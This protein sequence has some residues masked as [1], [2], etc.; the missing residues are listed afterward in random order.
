MNETIE[1]PTI[2]KP[3]L[4]GLTRLLAKTLERQGKFDQRREVS[5]EVRF[6]LW[7][8]QSD[9]GLKH[10]E[11]LNAPAWPWE[12]AGDTRI[13]LADDVVNEYVAILV[14]AFFRSDIQVVPTRKDQLEGA[15]RVQTFLRWLRNVK[16]RLDLEDEV[17]L[18]AQFMLGDDPALCVVGV[19]WKREMH[20]LWVPLAVDDL[21]RRFAA[22]GGGEE[23]A[24]EAGAMLSPEMLAG[25]VYDETREDDA[26]ALLGAEFP[27]AE[28]RDLR[29]ALKELRTS[30]ETKLPVPHWLKNQPCVRAYR[31]GDDMFIPEGTASLQYA[32]AIFTVEYLTEADLRARVKNDDW[33]EDEVD[34]VIK[35]GPGKRYRGEGFAPTSDSEIEGD[36]LLRDE[37]FEVW[38]GWRREVDA[39]GIMGVWRTLW[40]P[41]CGGDRD[42]E[43]LKHEPLDCKDTALP[44]FAFRRERLSRSVFDSRSVTRIAGSAQTEIK[45][46]RDCRIN[47]T[48]LATVPPV[49]KQMRRQGVALVFGP[50]AEVPIDRGD[51]VA[52]LQPPPFPQASIEMEAAVR[53][54][55]DNYFGR[56]V[57]GVAP[58]KVETIRARMVRGWLNGWGWVFQQMLYL[59]Q[60]NMDAMVVQAVTGAPPVVMEKDDIGGDY[61]LQVSFDV[62]ELNLEFLK[63]RMEYYT[64]ILSLDTNGQIDRAL[65]VQIAARG[66]D[67]NLADRLVRDVGVVTAA[68]AKDEVDAIAKIAVAIEVPPPQQANWGLRLKVLDETIMRSLEL[69]ARMQRDVNF[70]KAIEARR[71]AFTFQMQQAQNAQIGRTGFLPTQEPT[72]AAQAAAT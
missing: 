29:R 27:T 22:A 20:N 47:Y 53:R 12:G 10:A 33:D 43:V 39:K 6:S 24:A 72:M 50:A 13:F 30:G 26:L 68:E 15:M 34:R 49:K 41:A 42:M 61:E 60:K 52:F 38:C 44:F 65:L 31:L 7:D 8:G 28:E 56:E 32:P 63:A 70:A 37:L 18:T 62:R 54:D 64:Q 17:E 14:E 35:A 1:T 36:T 66:V 21:L 25:L 57:D 4:T 11:E 45:T 23:A 51:D 48:Q 46:Q 19:H 5:R 16:L 58:S 3:A 67:P 71:E 55:V 69:Q 9:D 2:N 59:C 40:S